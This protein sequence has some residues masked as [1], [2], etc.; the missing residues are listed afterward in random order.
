MCQQILERESYA[1]GHEAL[2]IDS[3]F[4]DF[5]HFEMIVAFSPGAAVTTNA[6]RRH[7]DFLHEFV[8]LALDLAD[9]GQEFAV[10][11][12]KDKDILERLE[13]ILYFEHR[14]MS[15]FCLKFLTRTKVKSYKICIVLEIGM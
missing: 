14:T 7:T 4:D 11:K 1:R 5:C 10:C 13:D 3:F 6:Q 15:S 9:H 8:K 2:G 12:I